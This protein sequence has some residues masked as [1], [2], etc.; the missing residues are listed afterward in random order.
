MRLICPNCGAQYEIAQDVIPADGRE[1]QCSNCA[2][3]WFER[4][5][6][7][8]LREA[9]LTPPAAEPATPTEAPLHSEPD[10][11][12]LTDLAEADA[13][14]S[15]DAKSERA[16]T[17]DDDTASDSDAEPARSAD[18]EQ[19]TAD[20]SP[21][22][23]DTKSEADAATTAPANAARS[24]VTPTVAEILREEAAREEAR[25]LADSGSTEGLDTQPD[26]GL[27]RPLDR[28]EQMA[29]EARR[30]M[31]RLK[32]EAA[33]AIGAAT[34]AGAVSRSDALP[35]VSEINTSL[36]SAEDSADAPQID[37][38]ERRGRRWRF[39]FSLA[40]GIFLLAFLAYVFADEISAAIPALAPT[41]EAYV[42]TIDRG[43]LW[44]DDK[45]QGILDSGEAEATPD[46]QAPDA[47]E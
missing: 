42:E 22:T 5:G 33:P 10:G 12:D 3:T 17:S 29:E 8:E 16:E 47:T 20:Q 45:A 38:D 7:S 23:G 31:A 37:E 13:P 11:A 15:Y 28:E 14:S 4:P 1:V 40:V 27:D 35:D 36:R 26:L 9:G 34:A 19:D 46:E 18:D 30:R 21:D 39:G 25:R 24:T 2:H 32:G 43:R 6:E 41:L 44:L